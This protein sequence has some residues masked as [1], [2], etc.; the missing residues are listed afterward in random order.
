LWNLFVMG[1]LKPGW[2]IERAGGHFKTASKGWFEAVTPTGYDAKNL[3][4]WFRFRLTAAPAGT[5]ISGLRRQYERSL[6]LLLGIT[7]LVLLIA[8]A[9]LANLLLARSAAREREIAVRLALGAS[10]ARLVAQLLSESL[11]LAVGGAALGTLLASQLSRGL[12][13]FLDMEGRSLLLDLSPDWR[14]LMFTAAVG[15]LTCILFG[16]APAIRATR[17]SMNTGA[18][19]STADRRQFSFQRLLITAQIAISLVLLVGAVLFV[20]SFRAILSVD[21][22]FRQDGIVFN[23][24][25]FGP[26]PPARDLIRPMQRE[27]LERVQALPGIEA[28]ATTTHTPL[29]GNSWTLTLQVPPGT[30]NWSKFT[31]VSPGFFHT[32]GIRIA[33]GRDFNEFDTENSAK[34]LLVNR[35]F[36]QKVFG[37]ENPIG[38]TVRSLAEPGYKDTLYEVIGLVADTKYDD[39]RNAAPPIAYAPE[40]QNPQWGPWMTVVVRS[41]L[42]SAAVSAAVKKS[43][44][45]RWP[46]A[47]I[48]AQSELRKMVSERLV[49]ERM[50]AWLSGFFG[51][52]ACLLAMLGLYGVISYMTA[53]RRKEIGIRLALGSSRGRIAE[54]VLRQVLT[55]LAAGSAVGAAAAFGLA[56]T[57]ST[58]LFGIE[59][60]DVW[61]FAAAA[62][63]LGVISLTAS[64]APALS[65]A[66]LNPVSTLRQD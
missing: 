28:T 19:G 4:S 31:W 29:T 2:T 38:K 45:E 62:T 13:W 15:A 18:R 7:G 35:S 21:P 36:A 55:P 27:A 63:A 9:N 40:L 26:P 8:C 66:K 53:R 54:L 11:L 43:I 33:S 14:L 57:A 44:V 39:L 1:R 52:L 60:R 59:P 34:V 58:L 51:A 16:L 23:W 61:T 65:A 20:Q 48:N 22:G 5:G 42:P 24:F 17:G 37:G 41:S 56:Q 3:K 46:T 30:H 47:R 6:W 50:L 25:Q 10:R 32:M 64:L 12:L 49:R